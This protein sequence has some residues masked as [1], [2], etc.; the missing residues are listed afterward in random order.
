MKPHPE[1]CV[2][3]EILATLSYFDLFSYP[4][5]PIEIIKFLGIDCNVQE[6][7]V[8]LFELEQEESIFRLDEFYALHNNPGLATRRRNG[9]LKARQQLVIADRIASFLAGFP[10]VTGIAVSGSLS[11]NFADEESD[12]DFFIITKANRLWL[13]RTFMHLFKKLTFLV[14]KQHYFCMNYYIDQ[15]MLTI[16][17]KNVYTAIEVATLMPL[18]GIETF[19]LFYQ[20][21]KWVSSFLPNHNMHI[22]YVKANKDSYLKKIIEFFF[23]NAAGNYL[24]SLFMKIT[25]GKWAK[26]TR[27]KKLS[28]SGN[29]MGMDAGKHYAKPLP[30]NF[31]IKLLQRYEMKLYAL[32]RE[33]EQKSGT[34]MLNI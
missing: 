11:K 24:D 19:G 12:V 2:K 6:I 23:N 13:A 9:N 22:T 10:F 14:G 29:V 34:N 4:L 30:A 17:E 8:P 27:L 3:K 33:F 1:L 25:A 18:R 21:N 7:A 20:Q 16:K 28:K 32:Y 15:D 26:K 5:T 31:Q